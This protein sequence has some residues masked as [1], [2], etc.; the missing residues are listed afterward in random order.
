M[1]QLTISVVDRPT[2]CQGKVGIRLVLQ[3]K[4]VYVESVD[5]LFSVELYR[6]ANRKGEEQWVGDSVHF[7]GDKR[8]FIYLAWLDSRGQMFR[9]IKLYLSQIAD[10][11]PGAEQV[12]VTISGQ[13][14]DG[15]PACSTAI[16]L[17]SD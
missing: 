12:N 10:L 13:G 5:D 3:T 1:V 6:A 15:S 11:V 4:K 7:H 17:G 16:V 9:R 8:R 2:T 14:K